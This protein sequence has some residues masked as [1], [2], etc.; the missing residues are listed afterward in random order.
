ME[1]SLQ[2]ILAVANWT[3]R[4]YKVICIYIILLMYINQLTQS[5]T[6]Q[7]DIS[8]IDM[9]ISSVNILVLLLRHH[10]DC[11]ACVS[12][13]YCDAWQTCQPPYLNSPFIFWK[14]APSQI[15][16]LAPGA[17]IRINK[18]VNS[19]HFKLHGT[20]NGPR[21]LSQ[22]WNKDMFWNLKEDKPFHRTAVHF[23]FKFRRQFVHPT[24]TTIC[25]VCDNLVNNNANNIFGC[26]CGH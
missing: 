13:V 17:S 16:V 4:Q 18:V 26:I 6:L 9:N 10:T 15:L 7:F 24:C 11:A 23:Y 3:L 8:H 12:R 2:L 21:L 14:E 22:L 20:Y 1:S 19:T 25:A 5:V